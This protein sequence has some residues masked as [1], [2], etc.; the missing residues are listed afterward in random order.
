[1]K[2]LGK[3]TSQSRVENQQTQPTYDDRDDKS[4]N[5]ARATLVG[6]KCSHHCATTVSFSRPLKHMKTKER[7][8]F[9]GI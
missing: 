9:W 6:G 8:L 1:M 7:T 2:Y 4:G 5:G 3:K